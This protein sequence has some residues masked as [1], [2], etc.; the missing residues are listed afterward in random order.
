M[1]MALPLGLLR[2][3]QVTRQ[4]K[5]GLAVVFSLGLVI[6]AFAI[7]RM[8]Q[9]LGEARA[10]PAGLALWGIVESSVSVVVGSLPPLKSFLQKKLAKYGTGGYVYGGGGNA[11]HYLPGSKGAAGSKMGSKQMSGMHRSRQSTTLR[12]DEI[13][14]ED[15]HDRDS[16]NSVSQLKAG[17]IIVTRTYGWE[18]TESVG[19]G[20]GDGHSARSIPP[21]QMHDDEENLV[22]VAV[23]DHRSHRSSGVRNVPFNKEVAVEG[24]TWLKTGND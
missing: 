2:N 15:R 6:V 14:L 24:K 20:G 8:T 18:R 16:E 5:L 7:I 21:G 23:S 10:D 12:D 13:A 17:E 3:L 1:I 22:G 19:G 4:Q 9:I 11:S